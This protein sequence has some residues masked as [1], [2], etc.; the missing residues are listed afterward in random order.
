MPSK[1]VDFTGTLNIFHSPINNT[2]GIDNTSKI[3]V[4]AKHPK[5]FISLDEA[6]HLLQQK[7]NSVSAGK[8]LETL[9]DKYI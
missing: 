8:V 4:A 2:V 6:D 7:E 3:F 9:A 5:I 1:K